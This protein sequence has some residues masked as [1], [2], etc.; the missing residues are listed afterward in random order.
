MLMSITQIIKYIEGYSRSY[1]HF[2]CLLK[3][4]PP[5]PQMN[6]FPPLLD[7]VWGCHYHFLGPHR[8][9]NYDDHRPH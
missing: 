9:L 1:H 5:H 2:M 7:Q 4:H 3:L 6:H 8:S